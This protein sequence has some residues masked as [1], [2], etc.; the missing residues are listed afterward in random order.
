M[1]TVDCSKKKRGRKISKNTLS[2]GR[3]E[4]KQEYKPSYI[5]SGSAIRYFGAMKQYH[6]QIFK[7]LEHIGERVHIRIEGIDFYPPVWQCKLH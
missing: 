3:R 2:K 1:N 5:P 6:G 7:V 4:R